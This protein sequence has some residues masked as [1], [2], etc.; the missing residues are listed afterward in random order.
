MP[1]PEDIRLAI[2]WASFAGRSLP[3]EEAGHKD[4]HHKHGHKHHHKRKHKHKHKH[5]HWKKRHGKHRHHWPH[6]HHKHQNGGFF[7]SFGA[8]GPALHIGPA[9]GQH[10]RRC[11]G[12]T[13]DGYFHGRYAKIGGTMCYDRYGNG[14]I[15]DGSRYLIHYY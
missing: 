8:N 7:L 10:A 9:P 14:Y 4:K 6:R 13:T 1:C 2:S 3:I 15:V 11:H 12:I 5:K